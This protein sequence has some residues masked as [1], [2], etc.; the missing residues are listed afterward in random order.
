MRKAILAMGDLAGKVAMVTGA[1]SGIGRA[2]ALLFAREGAAVALLD[3]NDDL[4]KAL[5]AEIAGMECPVIATHCDVSCPE[6]VEAATE[7]IMAQFRRIDI[8]VNSAGVSAGHGRTGDT[9]VDVW[10]QTIA[11]NLRGSF[12]TTR[13]VLPHMLDSHGGSIINLGSIYGSSGLNGDAAY[14]ASKGGVEQLTRTT[15]LEYAKRGIRVNC[16]AP[17]FIETPLLSGQTGTLPPR[18]LG[19]VSIPMGRL[20]TPEEVA[21]VALFLA[22]ERASFVTG[23]VIAV[24]GGMSAR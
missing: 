10:D 7:E 21:E 11:I 20:G 6:E 9:P 17:G 18:A 23:A 12:L 5:E 8:L 4:L 15:A 22:S 3:V 16:I 13:A 14:S 1:G 24:D 2:I 19:K